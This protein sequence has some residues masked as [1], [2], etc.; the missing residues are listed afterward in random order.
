MDRT[1]GSSPV[2]KGTPERL[3][4][5]RRAARARWVGHRPIDQHRQ[6]LIN[7]A[8]QLT[9]AERTELIKALQEVDSIT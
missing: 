6:V 7:H 4:Q 1:V 2:R 5:Q 3:E 8:H 9:A